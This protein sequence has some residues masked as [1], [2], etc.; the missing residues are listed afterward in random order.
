MSRLM[1]NAHIS[2]VI[3]TPTSDIE[4]SSDDARKELDS[5]ANMVFLGSNSFVFESTGRTC[6]VQPF[7]SNLGVANDIPI[8]D[9]DLAYDYPC[10]GKVYVLMFRNDPYV[11]SMGHNLI[12]SFIMR[13]GGVIVNDAPKIHSEDPVVFYYCISF[14]HSNLRIPLQLNGVFSY[15]HTRVPTERKTL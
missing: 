7:S 3:L 15:F 14:D 9:R 13:D 2:E 5:H 11:P 10:A 8:I 4:A 1:P 6:N 12:P